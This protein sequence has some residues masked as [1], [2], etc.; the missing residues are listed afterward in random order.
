MKW[1]PLIQ[2]L[3]KKKLNKITQRMMFL[4]V[5]YNK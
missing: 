1:P 4:E 3:Q 2:L 5:G